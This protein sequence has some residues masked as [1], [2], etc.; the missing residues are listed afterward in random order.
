MTAPWTAFC[1]Q[2]AA[3]AKMLPDP[4]AREFV[5]NAG[6]ICKTCKHVRRGLKHKEKCCT[7]T[8]K[9]TR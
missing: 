7:V 5:M 2:W 9:V 3:V 8:L 4:W 1:A 6:G